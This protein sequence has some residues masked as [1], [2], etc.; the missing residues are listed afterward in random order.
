[1][2]KYLAVAL[3]TVLALALVVVFIQ[4]PWDGKTGTGEHDGTPYQE[5]VPSPAPAESGPAPATVTGTIQEPAE[6]TM[7]IEE[8]K[9]AGGGTVSTKSDIRIKMTFDDEEVMVRMHDNPSSRDF[10][11]LLPLTVTLEDYAGTE[12]IARLSKRLSTND[13]P[14]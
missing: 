12:K 3:V 1:V 10:L 6:D 11:S 14:A 8:N 13:A 5:G 9:T 4:P 2:K 7:T